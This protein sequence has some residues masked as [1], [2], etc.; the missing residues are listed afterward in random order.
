MYQTG[1]IQNVLDVV[2]TKEL[3]SPRVGAT[4]HG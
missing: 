4:A 3:A 2:E 1:L